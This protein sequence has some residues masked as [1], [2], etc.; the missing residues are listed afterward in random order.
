MSRLKNKKLKGIYCKG[1]FNN[2]RGVNK[3]F[4]VINISFFNVY[5]SECELKLCKKVGVG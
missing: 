3:I 1:W 5:V 2:V 4:C